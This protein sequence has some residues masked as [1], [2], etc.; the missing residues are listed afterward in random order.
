MMCG[1][2]P[3]LFCALLFSAELHCFSVLFCTLLCI[4]VLWS[5]VTVLC[6]I[7]YCSLLNNTVFR[8]LLCVPVPG[9]P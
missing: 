4:A 9:L 1:T 8:A 3:V 5:T 2:Y 7:V 6:C